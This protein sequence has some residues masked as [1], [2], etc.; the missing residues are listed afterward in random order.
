M[1]GSRAVRKAE[2][3]QMVRAARSERDRALVMIGREFGLRVSEALELRFRDFAGDYLEIRSKK[4]SIPVRPEI[5][6]QVRKVRDEYQAQGRQVDENSPVFMGRE[7]RRGGQVRAITT[8]FS[9]LHGP[10]IPPGRTG[11]GNHHTAGGKHRKGIE[12]A[13]KD[14]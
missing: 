5:K 1:R 14:R 9:C 7:Y 3:K 11:P 12:G 13:G 8:Q 2:L 6:K 4:H 10:G